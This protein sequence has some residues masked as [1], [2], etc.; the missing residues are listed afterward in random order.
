MSAEIAE[1]QS[2]AVRRGTRSTGGSDRAAAAGAFSTTTG[3]PSELFI[4]SKIV[5]PIASVPTPA[6]IPMITVIDRD[7]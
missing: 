4:C 7:G 5:R 3:W 2:V 1:A 6:G